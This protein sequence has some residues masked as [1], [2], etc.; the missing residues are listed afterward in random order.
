MSILVETQL[1][2]LCTAK[3]L[4]YYNCEQKSI[5]ADVPN[6]SVQKQL[7]FPA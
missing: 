1:I 7:L 5:H 3:N 2:Y 6:E 4:I